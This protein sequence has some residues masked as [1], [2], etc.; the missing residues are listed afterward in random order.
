MRETN[1]ELRAGNASG[2]RISRLLPSWSSI[3]LVCHVVPRSSNSIDM[4][5]QKQ[6]KENQNSQ[7]QLSVLRM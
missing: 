6:F 7:T 5:F 3:V 4:G 2:I 1:K